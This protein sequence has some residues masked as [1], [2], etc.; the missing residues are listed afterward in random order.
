M[1]LK[2]GFVSNDKVVKKLNGK[3]Q[4]SSRQR[5]ALGDHVG[6]NADSQKTT[7]GSAVS[8]RQVH[9]SLFALSFFS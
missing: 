3:L 2:E 5:P 7:P 9:C 8:D 4:L 1:S 6:K